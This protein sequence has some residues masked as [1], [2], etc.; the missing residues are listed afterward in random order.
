M[1]DIEQ[2]AVAVLRRLALDQVQKA[3]SGHL[4]MALGAA[5]IMAA[6]YGRVLVADPAD[7]DWVNRDRFVLSAG[8]AS[9]L[10]YATLHCA[11][12]GVTADDLRG[13]RHLGSRTPGHPELRLAPGVEA[14]TGPL[15]Q[16]IGMAVGMAISERMARARL[17]G[18]IDHRVY[19]LAGDG[20]MMEGVALESCALAGHL[21]LDRLTV[22]FD[23][24][25][26]VIDTQASAVQD[27]ASV[28]AALAALGW[29]VIGPVEGEDTDAIADA[30]AEAASD[31]EHPS[32]IRVKTTAGY[33]SS[34][35]G[36]PAIHGG[37]VSP[38][39]EDHIRESLGCADD[40]PFSVPNE[41]EQWW[42]AG[43]ATRGRAA[44]AAHELA[45]KA[46]PPASAKMRQWL[47]GPPVQAV[48]DAL[49]GFS[50]LDRPEFLRETGGRALTVIAPVYDNLVGGAADLAGP[51]FAKVP[52]GGAFGRNDPTGRNIAYGIREHAMLAISNGIAIDRLFRPFAGTFMVFA[53]YG[54]GAIRLA[55][56][57][58]LPVIWMFTHDSLTVGEDGPTHQPVETLTWLRSL[59]GVVT[60][61]PADA[62][63][64]AAAWQLAV[65][66][67]D[68]PTCLSM[69][70][71]RAPGLD[72]SR[73][74]GAPD[75]GAYVLRP[76]DGPA[77]VLLVAS[78]GEVHA[79]VA[80]AN[81]LESD[82]VRAGVVSMMSHE[83]FLA[84]DDAYKTQV[85]T[86]GVPRLVIEAGSTVSLHRFCGERDAVFGLD[87]F[88][89]SAPPDD[90]LE[91]FGFTGPAIASAARKLI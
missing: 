82:G 27:S 91:H 9:A 26:V 44:H 63:E 31:R 23:D 13:F 46:D 12:Y 69:G 10:L 8:H 18:L 47:A 54:A 28:C 70:R 71:W 87:T 43:F 24:N 66:R 40:E 57:Q 29:Q 75:K 50:A 3:G 51:T 4:A 90:L 84:Q 89:A 62:V 61:R 25:D 81:L 6:L 58:H 45:I 83:V 5:P 16:G 20:C 33:G 49:K 52:G 72:H 32:L 38:A 59:P 85:L 77:D 73:A 55:A 21:G 34:L 65:A 17:D 60:L 36:T 88:G 76:A 79:A 74:V 19:A 1:S 48:D 39:E 80:A 78:G 2:R 53:P 42:Q 67:M 15:G 14:T 11:G 22:V 7:P 86:P 56:L 35:A 30:L 41:V 37:A 68:G 64:T